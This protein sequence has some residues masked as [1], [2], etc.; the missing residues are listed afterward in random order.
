[1]DISREK[2]K[3]RG[4]KLGFSLVTTTHRGII[5]GENSIKTEKHEDN[6]MSA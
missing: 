6:M 2:S 3:P 5:L 4:T 1:M